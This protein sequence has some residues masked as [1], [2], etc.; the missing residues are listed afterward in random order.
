M[1]FAIACTRSVQGELM[2]SLEGSFALR[3]L[4]SME[5]MNTKMG[6]LFALAVLVAACGGRETVAS[7]SAAAYREAG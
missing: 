4:D 1:R 7:K 2:I 5:R 3:R 6:W